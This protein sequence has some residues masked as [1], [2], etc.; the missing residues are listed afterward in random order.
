MESVGHLPR[1]H[2]NFGLNQIRWVSFTCDERS[3]H[4]ATVLD[5]LH[6][7]SLSSFLHPSLL[8]CVPRA[9]VGEGRHRERGGR[10]SPCTSSSLPRLSWAQLLLSGYP[11]HQLSQAPVVLPSHCPSLPM[12]SSGFLWLLVRSQLTYLL[13]LPLPKPRLCK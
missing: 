3:S 13:G 5:C 12:D 4:C 2:L 9:Q 8:C 1:P 10:S 6:L 11:R 7:Q